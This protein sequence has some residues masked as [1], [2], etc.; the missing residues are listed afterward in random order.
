ML[1]GEA[2]HWFRSQCLKARD[3]PITVPLPNPPDPA[4]CRV[5]SLAW[6]LLASPDVG[7]LHRAQPLP[8]V[9]NSRPPEGESSSSLHLA[10]SPEGPKGPQIQPRG[11]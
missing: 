8:C 2:Q 4:Q 11:R 7:P 3:K 6:A 1:E 9:R 10:V 5:P